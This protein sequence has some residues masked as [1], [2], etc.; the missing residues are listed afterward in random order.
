[1]QRRDFLGAML[2]I[3]CGVALPD[4]RRDAVQWIRTD[5]GV[6]AIEHREGRSW[7]VISG[8]EMKHYHEFTALLDQYGVSWTRTR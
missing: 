5:A 1:M 8:V 2:A 4:T 3:F 6:W 7:G